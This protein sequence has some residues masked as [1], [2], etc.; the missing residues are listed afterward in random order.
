MN[1]N[2]GELQLAKIAIAPAFRVFSILKRLSFNFVLNTMVG[3][4][5]QWAFYMCSIEQG[6]VVMEQILN[7]IVL[8]LK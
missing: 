7:G 8:I 1:L 3:R 2:I 6:E 5:E 4:D